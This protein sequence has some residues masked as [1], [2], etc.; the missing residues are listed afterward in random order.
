ML[1][2]V[3]TLDHRRIEELVN[4]F[5]QTPTLPLYEKIRRAYVN[6]IYWEEEFLFKKIN[7]SS[8]LIIIKSL[9]VEHGSMWM[10][11]DQAKVFLDAN[12]VENAKRKIDEFMR[13][14]L[15][16]DGAEEGSVYPEL[17]ALEE[18]EQAM[19]ILEEVKLAVAPAY[20]R[21]KLCKNERYFR[22]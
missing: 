20:W 8:L 10:L 15:E 22:S 5:L 4:D 11:L 9:E 21:C 14:L 7:N 17:D 3:L 18:E 19:L 16:H 13:V 2:T 1:G 6:H 12:D